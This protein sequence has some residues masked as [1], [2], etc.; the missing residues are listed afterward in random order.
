MAQLNNFNMRGTK[1]RGPELGLY[2]NPSK[3]EWSWLDSNCAKPCPIQISGVDDHEQ[4]KL[5]PTREIQMLGVPLGD[6]EFIADYVNKKLFP[7]LLEVVSKL[8]EFED[9]QAAM[10]LLR[11]SY[12]VVRAV[13][14]MRTTPINH[15]RNQGARFDSVVRDTAELILGARLQ[16]G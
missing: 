5:V 2:L 11:V 9:S 8:Q 16:A 14:F 12:S 7:R 3:C 1:S 15:W 4:V 6:P 13:H 10:Y